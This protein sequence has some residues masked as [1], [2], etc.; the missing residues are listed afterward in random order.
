MLSSLPG[1]MFYLCFIVNNF[2]CV[3]SCPKSEVTFGCL[4]RV[5]EF[6]YFV[7]GADNCKYKSSADE[8]WMM[9]SEPKSNDHGLFSLRNVYVRARARE[10]VETFNY[11]IPEVLMRNIFLICCDIREPKYKSKY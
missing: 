11:I 6:G 4:S 7:G 8:L 5:N 2:N 1:H 10:Y 3:G 9:E